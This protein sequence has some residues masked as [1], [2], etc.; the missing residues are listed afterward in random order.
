MANESL[1]KSAGKLAKA[2]AESAEKK[3]D[4]SKITE[5]ITK[6]IGGRIKLATDTT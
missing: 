3:T 6:A 4:F 5:P 1:I 2:Q